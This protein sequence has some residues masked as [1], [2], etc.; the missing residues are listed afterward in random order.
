[1]RKWTAWI[2]KNSIKDIQNRWK[3]IQQQQQQQQQQHNP[4]ISDRCACPLH[5]WWVLVQK[6]SFQWLERQRTPSHA[7][8]WRL[9]SHVWRREVSD[10]H[11]G[12]NCWFLWRRIVRRLWRVV[13]FFC[14]FVDDFSQLTINWWFGLV[15]WILGSACERDCYVGAP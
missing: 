5:F 9:P 3:F 6:T 4:A 14:F 1:M 15:V 8:R 13:S 10:G 2:C 12:K 7:S 11:I